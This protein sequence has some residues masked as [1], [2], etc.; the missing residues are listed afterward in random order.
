MNTFPCL[1]GEKDLDRLLVL[2]TGRLLLGENDL[3]LV[4]LL[5]LALCLGNGDL[6]LYLDEDG[7]LL[8]RGGEIDLLLLRL[9]GLGE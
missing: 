5:R 7:D 3:L 9:I 8:H 1:L 2:L 4:L 6:S